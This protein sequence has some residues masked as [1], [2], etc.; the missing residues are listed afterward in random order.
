M[1]CQI[2]LRDSLLVCSVRWPSQALRILST[3]CRLVQLPEWH[4]TANQIGWPC[5]GRC[6]LSRTPGSGSSAPTAH[7]Q[8]RGTSRSWSWSSDPIG[9]RWRSSGPSPS[10]RFLRHLRQVLER[11]EVASVARG[12]F[13]GRW[14]WHWR[15]LREGR[16]RRPEKSG[17]LWEKIT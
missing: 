3:S 17:H 15:W 16:G 1:M 4:S 2:F 7:R 12:R 8:A 13:R 9:S 14:G 11:V 6:Q 10:S 5:L